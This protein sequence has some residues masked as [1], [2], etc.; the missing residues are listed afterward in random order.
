MWAGAW[1]QSDRRLVRTIVI[2]D[3]Q[4]DRIGSVELVHL[5][6][7]I[8]DRHLPSEQVHEEALAVGE[9]GSEQRLISRCEVVVDDV[10]HGVLP[11]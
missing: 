7:A 4:V 11:A 5:I 10:D 9:H 1:E 3:D 6:P 2:G 8:D